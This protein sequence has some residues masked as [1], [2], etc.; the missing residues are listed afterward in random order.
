MPILRKGQRCEPNQER[1]NLR[2][3]VVPNENKNGA[4]W[5]PVYRD[6]TGQERGN[7]FGRGFEDK[8]RALH[9]ARAMATL[10]GKR[11]S[12]DWCVIIGQGTRHQPKFPWPR[13]R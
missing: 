4:G 10:E 12:G 11:Y 2:Y 7:T 8:D 6:N 1:V 3:Y 5:M 9:R 13:R